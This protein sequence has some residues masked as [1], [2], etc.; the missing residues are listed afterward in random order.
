MLKDL[1]VIDGL[2]RSC[3]PSRTYT[4]DGGF[5]SSVDVVFTMVIVFAVLLLL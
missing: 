5:A 3:M 2:K 4:S 1:V